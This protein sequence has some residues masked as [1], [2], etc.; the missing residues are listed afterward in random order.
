MS[1]LCS[2]FALKYYT[3]KSY[4]KNSVTEM[5][6][7]AGAVAGKHSRGGQ[8]SKSLCGARRRHRCRIGSRCVGLAGPTDLGT[9]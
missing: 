8:H 4:H 3:S 6:A 5:Q 1:V 2:K 7:A 9:G